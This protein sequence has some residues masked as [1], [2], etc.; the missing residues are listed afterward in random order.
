MIIDGRDLATQ[1]ELEMKEELK[2]LGTPKLAAVI[3]GADEGTKSYMRSIQRVGEKLGIEVEIVSLSEE[4]NTEEV[5]DVISGLNS[6]KDGI[7]IGRPFPSHINEQQV[8][9][10]IL[11]EKD[12]DCLH[13]INLGFLFLGVPRFNPCTPQA[14]IEILNRTNTTIRGKRV[15]IIGR[16]NIVGK[17]LAIMLIQRGVDATVTVCHTKTHDL[18]AHTREAD[19]LIAAAGHPWLIGAEMVKQGAVVID[20]GVNMNDGKLVGDVNFNEVEPKASLITPVPGGVGP[21]TTRVLMRN[22]LLARCLSASL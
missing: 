19:I 9:T 7:I 20:V 17:P 3:V 15:T 8:I 5:K 21:I 1:I 18:S 12:I 16:S 11:P 22:A 13:P 10:S 4:S 6:K 14:V 2:E